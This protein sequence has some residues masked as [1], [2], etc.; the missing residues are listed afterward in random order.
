MLPMQSYM[1]GLLEMQKQR[2]INNWQY[3]QAL[4]QA[5]FAGIGTRQHP[6]YPQSVIYTTTTTTGIETFTINPLSFKAALEKEIQ[7]WCGGKLNG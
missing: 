6:V 3:E 1:E 7:D 4:T 5:R 2:D